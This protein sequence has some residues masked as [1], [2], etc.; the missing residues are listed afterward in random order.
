MVEDGSCEIGGGGDFLDGEKTVKFLVVKEEEVILLDDESDGGGGEIAGGCLPPPS[1]SFPKPMEGLHEVGP[2]PFLKKTFQMVED[3][4]TDEII[5]WGVSKKSF[6]VWDQHKFSGTLLNKYFKHNNF[7]SFIRQLNT[8]GFKKIDSDRWE[9]ANEEFQGGKQNLLKNIKRRKQNLQN[10]HQQ[11]PMSDSQQFLCLET[12]LEK[13]RDDRSKMKTEIVKLKQEQESAE[14][15]LAGIKQRI[16]NTECKQQQIF[17]FL[18]KAFANP[19]FL[20]QFIQFLM[21]KRELSDGQ[22]MK[23][24]RLVAPESNVEKTN[25]KGQNQEEL[26]TVQSEVSTLFSG[27]LDD[28]GSP[29]GEQKGNATTPHG[30]QCPESGPE[31]FILWEKLLEDDLICE[32]DDQVQAELA[33]HQSKMVLELENLLVTSTEWIGYGRD[34]ETKL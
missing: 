8:Y 23:K 21:H 25:G 16:E 28:D 5:S 15:C 29:N 12:E 26:A 2:T 24:R 34:L 27:S 7:S 22:I 31:N 13:L 1:P 10:S 4:E 9:F 17:M 30:L 11:G 6:I 3:P 20:N 33:D 19:V 32:T 14:S 18:A